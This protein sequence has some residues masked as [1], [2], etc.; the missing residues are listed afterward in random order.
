MKEMPNTLVH[1]F[2]MAVAVLQQS[3]LSCNK[4]SITQI[5]NN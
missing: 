1:Q 3:L 4:I 2:A 5:D